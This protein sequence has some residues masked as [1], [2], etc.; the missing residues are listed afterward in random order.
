MVTKASR[1]VLVRPGYWLLTSLLA[2]F[3]VLILGFDPQQAEAT[4]HIP[5]E[6]KRPDIGPQLAGPE[7]ETA[8]VT[9]ALADGSITG[10]ETQQPAIETPE[11]AQETVALPLET[12]QPANDTA[13]PA[14]DTPEI[15][16]ETT[17]PAG[18]WHEVTVKSG[19]SMDYIFA[20]LDLPPQQLHAIISQGGAAHNLKK[21]HPGQKLRF[22]TNDQDGLLRLEYQ[23]DKLSS[24]TVAR[25]GDAFEISTAHRT[26]ERRVTH[27]SGIINSSLYLAANEAGLPDSLTMEL[28][29]IFGWDIDFALDIRKGDQFTILYDEKYLDG[30]KVGTGNIL[31]AEFI[32]SGKV[33]QAVRYTD[34]GGNTDYYSLDGKSMR[35]AFLR[36]PVDYRRISSKFSLGRKHP[37]LNKIRAHKGVDYAASTGTPIRAT[38]DGKIIYRGSKGGYGKTIIIQ[39]GAKYSTLYAHMSGYKGGLRKGSRV[40]QGQ[41]IG[42]VGSSGLATGPHLHYELRINGVHRNPLSVKLPGAPPLDK[43]YRDDFQQKSAAL[44]AQLETIRSIQVA[45]NN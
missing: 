40:K 2:I 19:N 24:L 9:E 28:A 12:P 21:I 32:N 34:Q 7:P 44:I 27:A 4:R 36:T 25:N 35:K 38:G 3:A 16:E 5:L 22:L 23:I 37:I 6:I 42:Y 11:P 18:E 30:D 13:E 45:S 33:F 8:A 31:A 20:K 29:N 41:T 14:Q 26:P 15:A 10:S 17:E 39:H 43:K 1:H